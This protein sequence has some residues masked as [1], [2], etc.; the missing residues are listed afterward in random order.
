MA[1]LLALHDWPFATGHS[2]GFIVSN[3]N[4][5]R[6]E[7]VPCPLRRLADTAFDPLV[8]RQG[9]ND[10]DLDMN[11]TLGMQRIWAC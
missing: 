5:D 1:F 6:T 4:A 11:S 2:R 9:T 8:S 7:Q 3:I 10:Q